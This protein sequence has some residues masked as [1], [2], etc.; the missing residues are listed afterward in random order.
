MTDS[1]AITQRFAHWAATLTDSDIPSDVHRTAHRAMLDTLGVMIAGGASADIRRLAGIWPDQ[2]GAC[3]L[4]T[5]GRADAETAVLVNGAATHFWDF[6]DTSY[7]GIMHGSAV[8]FPTVLALAQ[9]TGASEDEARTA[10]IIGSEIT[11]VMADIATQQHY[12]HGWWST[13]TFGQIGAT[14]AAARLLGCSESQIAQAI[15]LSAAAAGGAKSVFG[16]N[17]KPYL[18]GE[19]A[20]RAIRFARVISAGLSGPGDGIEG[21]TGF[22]HLLNNDVA[23]PAQVETLGQRW[24]LVDPGLLI[25]LNPVCSAAHAAVEEIARLTYH[26]D[27]S[28]DDIDTILLEVPKLVR[29]SLVHDDPETPAQAQFSLPFAAA[30]AVLNGAV[31]LQDLNSETIH[32]A[33]IRSLMGKTRIY[34]ADDLSTD[35]ARQ[36]FPESARVRILLK[37]TTERTGF[38]GEAYGMP[39]KPLSD[40]DFLQ[41]VQDCL[42]FADCS[43]TVAR[44]HHA[45]L[46]LLAAHLFGQVTERHV[47]HAAP[48]GGHILKV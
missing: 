40:E 43:A 47:V 37:D 30:C 36:K 34:E 22:L 33:D 16:T 25:K 14:A 4:A 29:I 15:G 20:Q 23:S 32:S 12:F 19:A 26:A 21:Q 44:I 11:Y 2:S 42:A 41:K 6:D 8:V 35:E 9:E 18:A 10:F 38:C 3:G 46:L 39:G 27:I 31:R 24:R 13:V 7:T 1:H 48:A 28:L 45:D 17:A 5:G